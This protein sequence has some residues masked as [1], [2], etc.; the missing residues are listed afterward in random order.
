[1][2][3]FP[4]LGL[5]TVFVII[6]FIYSVYVSFYNWSFY[7]E[8]V[9]VGFDNFQLVF[10]DRHFYKSIWIGIKFALFVVPLQM[11]ASFLF[12]HILKGLSGKAA[13][14][15]KSAIYIPTVI[16]G[17]LAAIIFG[18]LYNYDGGVF[19]YLLSLIGVEKQAFLGEMKTALAA[20][21]LPVM[22]L[23]FGL[24]ALI[25]LAGLL[26]IPQSYYEAADMEGAGSYKKMIHITIPLM[27]NVILY[28]LVTGF[29]VIIQHW[30][31]PLFLTNGGPL[32]ETNTPS[33]Y[34]LN[35]FRGDTLQGQTIAGALLLFAVLGTIS[36]II[37]KVLSSDKAVDG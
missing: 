34:L 28:L 32:D 2:M 4:I 21:A 9:F 27:K 26:D 24:S 10:K 6:P 11:V 22:W 3:L 25:M 5:L 16:S 33:L 37:F 8:S 7:Q 13:G 15:V 36:A 14:V 12:A 30:E 17:I 29:I 1:M 20:L 23:G 19:N 18:L 31:L 35:H